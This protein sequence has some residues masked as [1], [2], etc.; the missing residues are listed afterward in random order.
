MIK[1]VNVISDT[2]IGGAGK[3]V[4][5]FARNYDQ[6][7]YDVSVVVPKGSALI[8]ELEKTPVKIIEIDGI[9]DKSLD[10]KALFKLIKIL[11][12]EE[13]DIV[14]THATSIARVAAKFI[15]GAD[16]Y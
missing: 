16:V 1:V 6:K 11:R 3:C 2:N 10:I 9:K 15:D 5:N 8:G 14:H 13:P 4:I 12:A 7:K